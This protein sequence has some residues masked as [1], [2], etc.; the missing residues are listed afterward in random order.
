MIEFPNKSKINEINKI[1][2]IMT[3]FKNFPLIFSRFISDPNLQGTYAED[4]Y[5]NL[6]LL[7]INHANP[8][9]LDLSFQVSKRYCNFL[10]NMHGG[11][12]ATLLDCTTTLA[13]LKVDKFMRKTVSVDFGLSF[14]NPTN[15]NDNL[16][17]KS[18]CTKMGKSLAFSDAKIF[19]DNKMIVS[20]RHV[21]AILKEHYF[22]EEF[23]K[24]LTS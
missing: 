14:L 6:K 21:K 5:R 9:E 8:N 24:K 17:I 7:D 18:E 20:Y 4:I 22:D 23:M 16:I 13:I 3:K 10:G 11:A 12:I 15:L 19:V 1:L 2:R